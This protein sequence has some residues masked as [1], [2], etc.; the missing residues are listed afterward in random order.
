MEST[1]LS[2]PMICEQCDPAPCETVC[3]TKAITRNAKTD[4]LNVDPDKC[5]GCKEC[6]G[7][8]PF[9]AV[10]VRKGV[11]LKCDLCDG[12]PEC[13]KVCVPG[14]IRYVGLDRTAMEKKRKSLEKRV[15]ALS[16]VL[17][18]G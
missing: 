4:A 13:A 1:C 15:K 5:T 7:A 12:E 11:A 18:A 17:G 10:S 8:C 3:P 6:I 16:A 2:V 9:G 14:A